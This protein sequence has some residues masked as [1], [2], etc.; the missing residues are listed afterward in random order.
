M[1]IMISPTNRRASTNQARIGGDGV[2]WPHVAVYVAFFLSGA[3]G[4]AYEIVWARLIRHVMGNTSAT[5]TTVLCAFMGGL[6]LG[7]LLGGRI[8]DRRS[9]LLR[10]IAFVELMIGT[11]CLSLPYLVD[12][13]APLFRGLA[14]WGGMSAWML[15]A[16]RVFLC[17]WLLLIP[18]TLM[19]ATLPM[20]GRFCQQGGLAAGRP[21]GLLY[22]VNSLGAA[23]GCIMTGF[24]LIPWLG[25]QATLYAA[26]LGSFVTG[27]VMFWLHRAVTVSR[28][29][30]R[31]PAG[32]RARATGFDA[33]GRGTIA[34]MVLIGYACAG[35][36]GMIYEVAWTRALSLL[37]GSTVYAFSM[38]LAAF[39]LGLA[40]GSGTF[41][42][43]ADRLRRPLWTLGLIESLVGITAL[44]VLPVV[45]RLPLH[46]TAWIAWCGADFWRVQAVELAVI[47]LVMLVPTTLMGAAFPV[48]NRLLLRGSDDTGRVVGAVYAW[49]TVGCIVGSAVA[50][51][52]LIPVLGIQR[53][54]FVGV[55]LN[56]AVGCV[57]LSLANVGSA[58]QRGAVTAAIALSATT[59]MAFMP[60]WDASRMSLGPF[61]Q[62]RR[63]WGKV[64][65][66]A[67]VLA[68]EVDADQ[69]LCHKEG[70]TTTVTV[71]RRPTGD[72]TLLVDGK[73]DA[74]T[75]ADDMVTQEMLAHV[76]LLIH[77]APRSA[78]VIGL[79]S[80]ITLGAASLHPL[81]RLACAEIAPEMLEAARLFDAWNHRVLDDPRVEVILGDAR[82]HL[83]LTDA[84]YDV[85][86]SEPSNPWIAGVA[87]LF[88]IEFFR[89]CRERLADGGVACIWLETYNM[90][91]RTAGSII[92][93]FHAV[94]PEMSI[95]VPMEQD[96][97]LIGH[98]GPPSLDC[99]ALAGR[100]AADRVAKD[101]ERIG[102][103]SVPEFLCYQATGSRGATELAAG[104]P[105]HTDDNAL[106]EF[107]TP[108][109]MYSGAGGQAFRE[110]VARAYHT[111]GCCPT[112]SNEATGGTVG[113]GTED[114]AAARRHALVG[115]ALAAE[116]RVVEAREEL[117]QAAA[118]NR[119]DPVLRRL[120]Q[121][122]IAR[123]AELAATRRQANEAM[124][125]CR[126]LLRIDPVNGGLN[127]LLGGLLLEV[128]RFGEAREHL[129]LAVAA[130][131]HQAEP[132]FSLGVALNALGE[133]RA[134]VG[135]YRTAIGLQADHV[136]AL[137]DL[138]WI[139][140]TDGDQSP[141]HE[142][143]TTDEAIS[144]A[145]KAA[146][147]TERKDPNILDTLGAAYANA[148]RYDEALAV[149]R[150][151]LVVAE[152]M[153]GA[154]SLV[155]ILRRR[156]V[157]YGQCQPVREHEPEP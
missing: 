105:L 111:A 76:P 155:D 74:S 106:L 58:L 87:D 55:A 43:I 59:A 143:S 68:R 49:N 32:D 47:L 1:R 23:A 79:A 89:L 126:E 29:T 44:L 48:A 70:V 121:T 80:G 148:G 110:R 60:A 20:L 96:L 9:D 116:G 115:S 5:L 128:G 37:V 144:H 153:R 39:I 151:A 3:C 131:P 113:R 82:N 2:R 6:A 18:A 36:A 66:D 8:A 156:I 91:S 84:R 133:A 35:V 45:D 57:F 85:I 93:T 122:E 119:S 99:R 10:A 86:I 124:N 123:I 75:T 38:M 28:A 19:G 73:P 69:V 141:D 136:G 26:C 117:R 104:T 132:H 95:W 139:L 118:I 22:A 100:M 15:A 142:Q 40:L 94:F 12:W 98:K 149:V 63:A 16:V 14:A 67:A 135:S 102:I 24:V 17:G 54:L 50:G 56:V 52:L 4:L 109:T 71:K 65:G 92:G 61:I 72:L 64:A 146:M 157:A 120:L 62:A 78:L 145:E 31:F 41:A 46:V 13:S 27:A 129:A 154:T 25:V 125:A 51:L 30:K 11:Y 88:T 81:E 130:D 112:C 33:A 103:R 53:T 137:N 7:S 42:G 127:F 21:I 34:A 150:E 134:A 140:A 108:R 152:G 77:A 97:L 114:L 101:L 107:A 138:A 90:D 147:L 83:W